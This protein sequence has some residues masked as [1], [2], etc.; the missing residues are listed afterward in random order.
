MRHVSVEFMLDSVVNLFSDH[1]PLIFLVLLFLCSFGLP[2]AK[3]LVVVTG[4][5]L[6]GRG[7]GDVL[8]LFVCCSIGLHAGDF[9]LYLLGRHLGKDGLRKRPLNRL[10]RP[11]H[12][13]AA[14]DFIA[15]NG[16]SSLLLARV[17]PFIRGPLY[18]LLGSLK[19]HPIRFT[20]I[21]YATSCLYTLIFFL[22]GYH[23]GHR[24]DQLM[25]FVRSGNVAM[26]TILFILAVFLLWRRRDQLPSFRQS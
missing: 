26:I 2:L 3:S 22:I 14:E 9:G 16:T 10:L 5:V 8:L 18:F 12:V 25:E 21:N 24:Q 17:T 15:R 4:G 6:A 20:A 1:G 13:D 11:R 7:N 19:M 23:V